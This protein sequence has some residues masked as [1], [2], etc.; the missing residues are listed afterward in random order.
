M[1]NDALISREGVIAAMASKRRKGSTYTFEEKLA[2]LAE[3]EK[4]GMSMAAVARKYG[5]ATSRLFVW[6]REL[7]DTTSTDIQEMLL[8]KNRNRELERLL[9]KQMLENEIL[10]EA[11]RVASEKKLL[12]QGNSLNSNDSQ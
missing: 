12:L 9:G 6:R 3:A 11:L 1:D 7:A 10:R 4:P 8:M 5:V 2:L